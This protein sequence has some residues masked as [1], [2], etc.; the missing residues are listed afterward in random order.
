[1]IPN[2]GLYVGEM[3]APDELAEHCAAERR[4]D[5]LLSA[6]PLPVTGAVGSPLN[7]VALI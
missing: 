5:F 4:Y 2:M 6:P 3:W 7:P 1:M